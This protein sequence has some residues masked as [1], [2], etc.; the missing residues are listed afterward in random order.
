MFIEPKAR[1]KT[2]KKNTTQIDVIK[3]I[4]RYIYTVYMLH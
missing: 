3:N 4:D 2:L 1:A